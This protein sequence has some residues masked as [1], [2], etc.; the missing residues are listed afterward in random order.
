MTLQEKIESTYNNKDLF[1]KPWV[2]K[3]YED[4]LLL[5]GDEKRRK[6]LIIGASRYCK[7]SFDTKSHPCPHAGR[8]IGMIDYDELSGH[9]HSCSVVH[10]LKNEGELFDI[11]TES[12]LNHIN[13][14]KPEYSYYRFE[15][16]IRDYLSGESKDELWNHVSF[17]NYLQCMIAKIHTPSRASSKIIINQFEESKHIVEKIISILRPDIIILWGSAT[18]KRNMNITSQKEHSCSRLFTNCA[19]NKYSIY[20]IIIE[21]NVYPLMLTNSHPSYYRYGIESSVFSDF[22]EHVKRS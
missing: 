21:K 17:I 3:H 5:K 7:C 16:D 10:S 9:K 11:N 22:V 6:V 12:M 18:I 4:G 19:L 1:F 8:C 2:G 13:G 20:D 14:T 15:K